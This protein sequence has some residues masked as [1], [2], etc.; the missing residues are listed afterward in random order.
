M[1]NIQLAMVQLYYMLSV[2]DAQ[3]GYFCPK[4]RL[5]DWYII[6]PDQ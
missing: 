2:R 5:V 3:V 6:S 1:I 4:N